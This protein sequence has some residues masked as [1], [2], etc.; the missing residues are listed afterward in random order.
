VTKRELVEEALASD[1]PVS[2]AIDLLRK[3]IGPC[4]MIQDLL[5]GLLIVYLRER[6]Q[7]KGSGPINERKEMAG[8][9]H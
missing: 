2:T 8:F 3:N 4:P 7:P 5:E 9:I 1:F 6:Y